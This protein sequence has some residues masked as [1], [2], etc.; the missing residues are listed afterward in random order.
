MKKL[1]IKSAIDNVL[2]TERGQK[3]LEARDWKKFRLAVENHLLAHG[4]KQDV[5]ED[6][7]RRQCEGKKFKLSWLEEKKR[8]MPPCITLRP[9]K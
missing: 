5:L 1:T 2:T 7:I 6:T 4:V 9:P 8:K 3:L